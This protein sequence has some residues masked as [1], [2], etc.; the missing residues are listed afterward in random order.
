MTSCTATTTG[1]LWTEVFRP[2]CTS[3]I[4]GNEAA[5]EEIMQCLARIRLGVSFGRPIVIS[6]PPGVGKTTAATCCLRE[7]G[8]SVHESNAMESRTPS[9]I[10]KL[11]GK[12]T[13]L[14]QVDTNGDRDPRPRGVIID[15]V[16]ACSGGIAAICK[17]FNTGTARSMGVICTCNDIKAS[18]LKPI[19]G[20]CTHVQFHPLKVKDAVK[21]MT[22]V[23]SLTKTGVRSQQAQSIISAANGDARQLVTLTQFMRCSGVT[24]TRDTTSLPLDPFDR[25]RSFDALTRKLGVTHCISDLLPDL[26]RAHGQDTEM[27]N[28]MLHEH[29][30]DAFTHSYTNEKDSR[31]E[32]DLCAASAHFDDQSLSDVMRWKV[33][34]GDTL[35]VLSL[36]VRT[37]AS[38]RPRLGRVRF[39]TIFTAGS[40]RS[41]VES[42]LSRLKGQDVL[43]HV[44]LMLRLPTCSAVGTTQ[45]CQVLHARRIERTEIDSIHAGFFKSLGATDRVGLVKATDSSRTKRR[46]DQLYPSKQADRTKKATIKKCRKARE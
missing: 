18:H 17:A 10:A 4:V 38:D 35:Q 6:G 42:V 39:P 22:R 45:L 8:F 7:A 27:L 2:D 13:R 19:L 31:I 14:L 21:V 33:C 1:G 43:D 24:H 16:D 11:L 41:N 12:Q 44:Q 29:S 26:E 30:I 23:C 36:G 34:E 25:Y 28:A 15:E 37:N 32:R 46:F 3:D 9:D 20:I 40:R 5:L